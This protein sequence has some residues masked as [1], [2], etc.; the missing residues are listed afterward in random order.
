MYIVGLADQAGQT[1][2]WEDMVFTEGMV[3]AQKAG[4][5]AKGNE[6]G[7]VRLIL[8]V[9]K[10]IQDRGC[11]ESGKPVHFR[12]FLRERGK[13][14]VPLTPFKG[15][16]FNI[17]FHNGGGVYYLKQDLND[18]F[19]EHKDNQ[20]LKAGYYD[21]SVPQVLPGCRAL[22]LINKIVTMPL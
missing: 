6:G 11:K 21:I 14:P 7:V 22:G 13:P 20:L 16:H 18:F 9:C 10:A 3:G 12:A 19:L 8:T 1:K 15:N 2:V 17:V 5:K 4:I